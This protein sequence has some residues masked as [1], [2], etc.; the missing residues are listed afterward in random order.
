MQ[1]R[2]NH[3]ES[4]NTAVFVFFGNNLEKALQ[5]Q[6]QECPG[7]QMQDNLPQCDILHGFN[8]WHKSQMVR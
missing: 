3:P 4:A 5:R 2:H 1:Q 7:G 8:S 6:E